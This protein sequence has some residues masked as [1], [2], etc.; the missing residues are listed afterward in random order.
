MDKLWHVERMALHQS[1]NILPY[2]DSSCTMP[3]LFTNDFK[4]MA[5]ERHDRLIPLR[6][7]SKNRDLQQATLGG[8]FDKIKQTPYTDALCQ[9]MFGTSLYSLKRT[10]VLNITSSKSKE[11]K[12]SPPEKTQQFLSLE[13]YLFLDAPNQSVYGYCNPLWWGNEFLYVGL[14]NVCHFFKTEEKERVARQ[15]V[16]ATI[17]ALSCTSQTLAQACTDA[18]FTLLDIQTQQFCRHNNVGIFTKVIPNAQANGFYMIG[19]KEVPSNEAAPAILAHYDLRSGTWT[20]A[21]TIAASLY[22]FAFDKR[23]TLALGANNTVQLWDVRQLNCSKLTFNGHKRESKA[24]AFSPAEPSLIASGGMED[25]KL[26]VWD[27][28]GSVHAEGEMQGSVTNIHW[29]KKEGFFATKGEIDQTVTCWAKDNK[30]LTKELS[31]SSDPIVFSAQN[32]KDPYSI[33]TLSNQETIRFWKVNA[34]KSKPM[35]EEPPSFLQRQIIR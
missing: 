22:D 23:T 27:V 10:S 16:T 24:I 35:P 17:S 34:R 26:Y 20:F 4:I 11:V 5:R 7:N 19:E 15:E 3:K 28:Y 30:G 13:N 32:P 25:S 2:F 1:D 9:A 18:S 14:D 6:K 8:T 29:L 31:T 12:Y 33:V 21:V